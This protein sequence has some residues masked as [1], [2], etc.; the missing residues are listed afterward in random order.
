MNDP[1]WRTL[2]RATRGTN[3]S[4][5]SYGRCRNTVLPCIPVF[6]FALI[7][8]APSCG[9]EGRLAPEVQ[10]PRFE[11]ATCPST[12]EALAETQAAFDRPE[13]RAMRP[14]LAQILVRDGGMR[15]AFPLF[16]ASAREMAAK[17]LAIVLA[18]HEEGRG[19]AHLSGHALALLSHLSAQIE[20][21]PDQ[22]RAVSQAAWQVLTRCDAVGTLRSV[23]K[24]AVLDIGD[25]QVRESWLGAVL[26]SLAFLSEQEQFRGWVS[27][28]RFAVEDKESADVT[29]RE[30]VLRAAQ[31]LAANIA[32]PDFEPS[33]LRGVLEDFL[34][35]QEEQAPELRN[36]LL[37]LIELLWMVMDPEL[38]VLPAVQS[39]AG[40]VNNQDSNAEIVGLIFDLVMQHGI[41][42]PLLAS[43]L[44]ALVAEEEGEA[45]YRLLLGV[46][47]VLAQKESVARD[48]I[49]KFAGFLAPELYSLTLPA[50]QALAESEMLKEVFEV[51]GRWMYGCAQGAE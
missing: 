43:D 37:H 30:A 38:D 25:G 39:V 31:L 34:L 14:H 24:I 29:G 46:D 21:D 7:A 35:A 49:V 23:A 26:S 3:T 19:L 32:S 16:V 5:H 17:D 15:L 18:G 33:Y 1:R 4:P 22:G 12:D 20:S 2:L 45:A 13:L 40:C 8:L 42:V 50:I 28:L 36:E 11:D 9:A 48:F 6:L 41:D 51:V 44:D 10:S 47:R 27:R